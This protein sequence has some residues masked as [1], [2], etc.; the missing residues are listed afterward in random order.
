MGKKYHG[1]IIYTGSLDELFGYRFGRLPFRSLDFRFETH[2]VEYYQ[3]A[4]TVH[5]PTATISHASLNS[6]TFTL[7]T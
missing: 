4:A 7:W 1:T 2:D 3:G 6:S 5:Y